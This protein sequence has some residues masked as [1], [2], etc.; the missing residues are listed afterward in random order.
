MHSWLAS[1][2]IYFKRRI[3]AQFFLGIP[4]GLPLA[5]SG[6]TLG[7]WLKDA[8]ISNEVIGI[9]AAVTLPYT[10]KFLWAP[11]LDGIRIPVVGKLWGLRR[12]WMLV[13]QLAMV[14]ALLLMSTTDP[15]IAPMITAGF[16]LLLAFSSAS[17][18][19]V[20]DAYRVEALAVDEQG[21]GAASFVLGYRVGML[22][23]GAGALYLADMYGWQ[24]TYIMMAVILGALCIMIFFIPEPQAQAREKTQERYTVIEWLRQYVVMP[25]ADF[26]TRPQAVYILL[27]ILLYRLTDGFMG[28]MA[29]PF[30]KELGF[31]NSEIAT[32]VK[33]YGLAA[34]IAGSLI[35]GAMVYRFGVIRSLWIG[36]I[37][38]A[39]SNLMFVWQAQ[40]G[41]LAYA[42]AVTISLDN[43]SAGLAT[44]A[45]IAYMSQLCNV[46]FTAT[47]YALLSSLTAF[48]RTALST[49]S[50][51]AAEW[52]GW[53]GFFILST[54]IVIP[55][56]VILCYLTKSNIT[57]NE[58]VKKS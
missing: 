5:L 42:L 46:R 26:M 11:L 18:D 44:A 48:G 23:S 19:I 22:V 6:A 58:P 20:K 57:I 39:L 2:E 50:G 7:Y 36:G 8:E 30:Y 9:F 43:L 14:V 55:A 17:H 32:V 13:T 51:E 53:E 16:A 28:V 15:L 24:A 4:S 41:A 40:V 34:T 10:I 47:Q 27:F 49:A 21:A 31:T 45:F 1:V 12:S 35:G 3:L 52:L 29:G 54:V 33:L 56:L 37:A 25:F 38:S